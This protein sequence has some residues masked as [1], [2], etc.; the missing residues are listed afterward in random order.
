MV[1]LAATVVC[2]GDAGGTAAIRRG[3]DCNGKG[4]FMI[5]TKVGFGKY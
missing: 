3:R 4:G 2:H 1:R 5:G